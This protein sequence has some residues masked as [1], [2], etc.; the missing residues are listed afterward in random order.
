MADTSLISISQLQPGT[1]LR[2]VLPPYMRNLGSSRVQGLWTQRPGQA[3][4]SINTKE[5]TRLR[6]V[7]PRSFLG[8]LLVN[9]TVEKFLQIEVLDKTATQSSRNRYLVE[10]PYGS[11]MR[12]F[13]LVSQARPM[14][15]R[16]EVKWRRAHPRARFY[17]EYVHPF[18]KFVP[19]LLVPM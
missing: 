4:A 18:D 11:F 9:N 1:F 12:L 15:A 7:N 8:A 5:W 2:A 19:V 17:K 10:V 14:N 16:D 3:P 6:G 13:R